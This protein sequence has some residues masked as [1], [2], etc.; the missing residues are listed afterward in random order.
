M[1]DKDQLIVAQVVFKG[2]I[3]LVNNDKIKLDE[4]PAFLSTWV[5]NIMEHKQSNVSQFPKQITPP[6]QKQSAGQHFC[7]ACKSEL[8]D[9]RETRRGNQPTF[10]CSNKGCTAGSEYQGK[11]QPWASWSESPTAEMEKEYV[12]APEIKPKS[13]DE[14]AENE[15]PF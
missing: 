12:E 9:N 14:I 7:P 6:T 10:K 1:Q 11:K 13:M 8:Y 2:A 3:D 15:A 4:I 5:E